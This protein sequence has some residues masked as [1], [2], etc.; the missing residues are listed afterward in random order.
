MKFNKALFLE[1]ASKLVGVCCYPSQ[2]S[3]WKKGVDP[4]IKKIEQIFNMVKFPKKRYGE[5]FK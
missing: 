5:L 3:N 1:H 4:S 2:L